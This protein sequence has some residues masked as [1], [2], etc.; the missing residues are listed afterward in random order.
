M[1]LRAAEDWAYGTG[2]VEVTV[3]GLV[4]V[5]NPASRA[6]CS[7][8]GLACDGL[9]ADDANYEQWGITLELPPESRQH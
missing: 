7:A 3:I 1:A 2:C 8:A 6:L 5:R 4:H 9:A